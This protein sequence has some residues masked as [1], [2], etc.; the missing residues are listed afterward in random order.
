MASPLQQFDLWL[1][2]SSAEVG[3]PLEV[4]IPLL[5]V[6]IVL[7]TALVLFLISRFRRRA[8]GGEVQDAGRAEA[9]GTLSELI[10][11]GD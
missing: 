3:I 6:N 10:E 8:Q 2:R 4:F 7:L 9:R 11:E 1:V 5:A